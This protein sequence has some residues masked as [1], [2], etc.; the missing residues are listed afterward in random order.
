MVYT[1]VGCDEC[2]MTGYRGRLAVTEIVITDPELER[3]IVSGASVDALTSIAKRSGTQSLWESGLA[4]LAN[5][6]TSGDELLRVLEQQ[7]AGPGQPGEEEPDLWGLFDTPAITQRTFDSADVEER[8]SANAALPVTDIIAGVVDVYVVRPLAEGWK[9][10]A[11]Q[12]AL[13]TRCPGAW[14]TIHGRLDAGE[15]PEDG[16]VREVREETGLEIARL[17][18]VTVQPFY[19]HMFGTVQL[20]IVFAAFV[21]EPAQVTLGPEHQSYEWLSPH[22]ASARFIWPREK[23]ALS[24]VLHLLAGGNAGPVEDVLRVL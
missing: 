20:A 23:E 1:P 11:V 14:E 5:G 13:D 10:L 22:D 16:A 9:V 17:Y 3:A 7:L 8:K 2:S 19:L 15:R 6:E 21:D 12:R 4:H 24:H 18:N